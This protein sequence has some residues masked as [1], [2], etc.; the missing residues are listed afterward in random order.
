MGLPGLHFSNIACTH[1]RQVVVSGME[2]VV[3]SPCLICKR[4]GH[5]R[6]EHLPDGKTVANSVAI[7]S[8]ACLGIWIWRYG[9]QLS[10]Q[11]AQR[12]LGGQ[13]K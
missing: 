1:G 3:L 11:A 2:E 8:L 5:F 9:V 13:V 4:P 7:C 12:L 6:V 10:R